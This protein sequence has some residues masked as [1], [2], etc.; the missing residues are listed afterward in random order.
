V[1]LASTPATPTEITL[2]IALIIA[3]GIIVFASIAICWFAFGRRRAEVS[4]SV[5]DV[6]LEL[7]KALMSSS[8]SAL[9]D[10]GKLDDK[11]KQFMSDDRVCNEILKF[12]SERITDL[13]PR[14]QVRGKTSAA[15]RVCLTAFAA[16]LVP[17]VIK[18]QLV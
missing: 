8:D 2:T 6:I 11:I 16:H 10:L 5:D 13:N 9:K 3:G 12:V 18:L 17:L 4:H 1:P 15:R 7:R 14:I